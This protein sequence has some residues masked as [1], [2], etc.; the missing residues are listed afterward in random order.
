[1]EKGAPVWVWNNASAT[2][3]FIGCTRVITLPSTSPV[4][5][6]ATPDTRVI[7]PPVR[8]R[9][10]QL[11][12]SGSVIEAR[13]PHARHAPT[14]SSSAPAVIAAPARRSEEHTSELQSRG[15]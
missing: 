10:R 14:A 13:L 9:N 2:A 6:T 5:I 11:V 4:I 12:W 7:H 1:M 8:A 15:H 3:I